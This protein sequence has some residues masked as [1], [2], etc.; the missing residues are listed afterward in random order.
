MLGMSMR[1]ARGTRVPALSITGQ[2]VLWRS[3]GDD[4]GH[5]G[6][7]IRTSLADVDNLHSQPLLE[8]KAVVMG[9]MSGEGILTAGRG[10]ESE[11]DP[12][13]MELNGGDG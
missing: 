9:A 12:T 2:N 1:G 8:R 10:C 6:R 5:G 7:R 3:A 11:D 4:K 13:R